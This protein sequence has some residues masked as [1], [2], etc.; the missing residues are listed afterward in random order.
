MS[1]RSATSKG[2]LRGPLTEAQVSETL[3][4][5]DWLCVRRFALEQKDKTRESQ[6]MTVDRINM[7][8]LD[9]M[10][11]FQYAFASYVHLL[12]IDTECSI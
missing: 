8:S 6:L 9:L 7:Q 4:F 12:P 11:C 5:D 10:D 2:W 3:G 1:S